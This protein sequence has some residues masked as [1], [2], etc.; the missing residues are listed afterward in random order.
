MRGSHRLGRR[1]LKVAEHLG[2]NTM[3]R[4]EQREDRVIEGYVKLC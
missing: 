4:R 2:G 3:Q 1:I